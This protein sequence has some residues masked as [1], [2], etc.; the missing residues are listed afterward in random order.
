MHNFIG[1]VF[2]GLA[3]LG[4]ADAMGRGARL[5]GLGLGL[6]ARFGRCPPTAIGKLMANSPSAGGVVSRLG[7]ACLAA[8]RVRGPEHG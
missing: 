2:R 7:A 6:G 4:G 3:A 5:L 8:A 1:R